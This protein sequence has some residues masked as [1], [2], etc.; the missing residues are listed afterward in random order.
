M[1]ASEEA[2]DTKDTASE[3][4]FDE[5][6]TSLG[7][8]RKIT[9]VLRQKE[10]V[11]KEVLSLLEL[12]DLKDVNFPMATTSIILHDT[13][14]WKTVL[15]DTN[16]TDNVTATEPEQTASVGVNLGQLEGAGMHLDN[17]LNDLQGPPAHSIINSL[18]QT[19]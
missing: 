1:S 6:A 9:K 17:L 5:W 4:N 7:L 2:Q 13:Y 14:K 15:R 18:P 10:L 16:V 3:F 8:S 19:A 11:T 12:K